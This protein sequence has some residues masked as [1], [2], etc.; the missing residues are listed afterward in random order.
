[1]LTKDTWPHYKGSDKD[2]T[3]HLMS[4]IGL[5]PAETYEL[6]HTKIFIK[7]PKTVFRLEEM[8]SKE[9]PWI[10]TNMQK[11]I[12][13]Y[14]ARKRFNK[15]LALQRIAG[16]FRWA[17]GQKH[18]ITVV[19]TFTGKLNTKEKG[20]DI[21]WPAPPQVLIK[22]QDMLEAIQKRW[23]AQSV[24]NSI[25]PPSLGAVKQKCLAYDIFHDKK[26]WQP[27]RPWK[28]AYLEDPSNHSLAAYK[29]AME[30]HISQHGDQSVKFCDYIDK[31][32]SSSKLDHRGI[33]VTDIN[34]YKHNPK[35]FKVRLEKA[36]PIANLKDVV[37]S[38]GYDQWLIIH[39]NSDNNS[40]ICLDLKPSAAMEVE[41]VS[42]LVT[43]LCEAYQA[44][45]GKTLPVLF[46]MKSTFKGAA[47]KGS[48]SIQF[49]QTEDAVPDKQRVR[50]TKEAVTLASPRNKK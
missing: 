40:D 39:T 15:S 19:H 30:L 8:R 16:F 2:G 41:K 25:S 31:L 28:A 43:V 45:T 48:V 6:G 32:N 20:L 5:P 14:L 42:E 33:V 4:S 47:K 17:R 7:E 27:S 12:R 44:R 36:I 34:I 26:Y 21:P 23:W 3:R 38:P 24:I 13:G 49:L 50:K 1:M 35:N 22:A 37:L 11:T 29:K 10:V 18:M 9:M 46:D